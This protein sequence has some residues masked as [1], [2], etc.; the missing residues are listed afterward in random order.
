MLTV[1][2]GIEIL[3]PFIEVGVHVHAGRS[4]YGR[5]MRPVQSKI[6]YEKPH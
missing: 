1:C 6:D 2:I 4:D 5:N 3:Q